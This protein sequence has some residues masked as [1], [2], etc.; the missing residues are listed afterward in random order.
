MHTVTRLQ[1][2]TGFRQDQHFSPDR[3]PLAIPNQG[4]R[5]HTKLDAAVARDRSAADQAFN[6]DAALIVEAGEFAVSWDQRHTQASQGQGQ[7]RQGKPAASVAQQTDAK[8]RR[9]AR[10]QPGGGQSG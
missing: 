8:Q 1:G 7:Q 9:R 5:R 6:A 10:K 3:M 4:R 2:R